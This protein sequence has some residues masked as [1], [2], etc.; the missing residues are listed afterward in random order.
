MDLNGTWYNELGSIMTLQTN[1]NII[2]GTYQTAVGDASGIYSL[3]GQ[4]IVDESSSLALGWVVVWQN[5]YGNSDSVTTWS[6]QLQSVNGTPTIVTTW[7][8]TSETDPNDDWHSTIVGKDVFTNSKPT[9]EEIKENL[10]KGIKHSF[11]IK[12]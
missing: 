11:R 4:I 9:V 10:K 12:E 7:L 1:G 8:L 5:Q 2:S 6:G 3:I